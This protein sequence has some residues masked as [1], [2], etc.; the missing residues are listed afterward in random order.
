IEALPPGIGVQR[1]EEVSLDALPVMVQ[2][3]SADYLVD[4][5]TETGEAAARAAVRRLLSQ[6]AVPYQRTRKGVARTADLRPVLLELNVEQWGERK[7]L[8]MRLRLD[9]GGAAVRP[10]EVV[11]ALDS[12]WQVHRAHRTG[13]TLGD[14]PVASVDGRKSSSHAA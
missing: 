11:R 10:D 9:R 6:P 3:S 12:R 4:V 5:L 7:L 13:L 14:A 1:V 8:A 2:V